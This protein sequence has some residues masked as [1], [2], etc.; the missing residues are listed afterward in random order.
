MTRVGRP[1]THNTLLCSLTNLSWVRPI[2]PALPLP[3]PFITVDGVLHWYYCLVELGFFGFGWLCNRSELQLSCQFPLDLS[4]T[5]SRC[6]RLAYDRTS[7]RF[8]RDDTEQSNTVCWQ[9]VIRNSVSYSTSSDLLQHH[10]YCGKYRRCWHSTS[11]SCNHGDCADFSWSA[12]R[13]HHSHHR[14]GLGIVSSQ[15]AFL[16][17]VDVNTTQKLDCT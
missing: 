14:C 7:R 16:Q 2:W 6:L 11:W 17:D 1:C 8:P 12:H 4:V 9:R 5:E 3:L 15:A 13:W 10:C